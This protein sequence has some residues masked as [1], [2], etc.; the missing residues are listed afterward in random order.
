M[1]TCLGLGMFLVFPLS[2]HSYS[3][4]TRYKELMMFLLTAVSLVAAGA[5]CPRWLKSVRRDPV[6]LLGV[7]Y[8]VFVLLSALFGRMH[9]VTNQ[10]GQSAVWYGAVRYEGM[11]TQL[12]YLAIFL[13]FSLVLPHRR[14]LRAGTAAGLA[15]FTGIVLLQY[16]GRNPLDLFPRGRS[17]QTNY[18]FQGTIGNIDMVSG[19][20]CLAV[21][22]LVLPYVLHG[23]ERMVMACGVLGVLLE[24]M[25]E[26]QS[27]LLGMAVL[28][29]FLVWMA[30]SDAAA[31]PRALLVLS[32]MSLCALARACVNLPW[33]DGGNLGFRWPDASGIMMGVL[34][35]ALGVLARVLP[36]KHVLTGKRAALLLLGLALAAL[37]ALFVIP[38][39]ESAG[40]LWEL[41]EILH[42]RARDEF[43]SWRWGVWRQ[44]LAMSG[45]SLLFGTGPDTFLYAFRDQVLESGLQVPET[46]D[47]PHSIPLAVLANHGLPALCL[48]LGMTCLGIGRCFRHGRGKW[49]EGAALIVYSIQGLFS[50]S[51]CIVSPMF[52]AL[53]GMTAA[54]EE[55]Y[56]CESFGSPEKSQAGA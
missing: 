40:G 15:L 19:Y 49:A 24:C 29:L 32:L 41:R 10:Q 11:L 37:T 8:F 44:T 53:L 46:F 28:A 3:G 27:G 33:L 51:I 21:P 52:W 9:E 34:A 45:K 1:F 35:A 31:R 48:F 36:G 54:T 6:R 13:C 22:M 43:G 56:D 50:F 38:V 25:M 12:C 2:F 7:V 5:T 17:V 16:L 26:V 23:R 14:M 55:T 18:E 20:L 4:I 30:L 39:P 42:G 47:N